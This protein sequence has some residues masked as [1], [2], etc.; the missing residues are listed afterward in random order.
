[1]RAVHCTTDITET[2]SHA[3]KGVGE[4]PLTDREEH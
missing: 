4:E 2:P 1:L 3:G